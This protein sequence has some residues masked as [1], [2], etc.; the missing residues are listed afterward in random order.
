M[1]K[2]EVNINDNWI[3]R[4][5]YPILGIS[6][7]HIGN[8]NTLKELLQI[9][10]Y[11]SDVIL[12][13]SV[14]YLLGFYI[15]WIFKR[16]F[17]HFDWETQV[18]NM[19]HYILLWS[20]LFPVIF[21]ISVEIVY[22]FFINIPIADSSIFYLEL[23]LVIAFLMIINLIY[24]ILYFRQHTI[25]INSERKTRV[26]ENNHSQPEFLM[27]KQG[28]QMIQV[29]IHAIAYFISKDKLTFLVTEGN[30]HLLFDKTMKEVM[31]VLPKDQFYRVN[32]QLITQK[33]S[34][35]KYTRT[36]TRR[37]KIELSPSLNED[38]FLPKAKA[39]FFINW[40]KPI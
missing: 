35:K 14:I 26:S 5:V 3:L 39:P 37:L 8:D 20:L 30:R 12:A 28:T 7:V 40:L 16:M 22:L 29:P 36:D 34:I 31:D 6:F 13:I 33:S 15:R 32:R 11:Y 10:S 21:A 23:P 19:I 9:P 1:N 18:N 27:A 17:K 4:Y 2:I 24:F 38:I 25:S